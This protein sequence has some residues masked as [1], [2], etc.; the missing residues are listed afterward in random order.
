MAW[1]LEHEIR[2]SGDGEDWITWGLGAL[3]GCGAAWG[4]CSQSG[5]WRCRRRPAPRRRRRPRRRAAPPPTPG[6]CPPSPSRPLPP[7][8]FHQQTLRRVGRLGEVV[9]RAGNERLEEERKRKTGD[10]GERRSLLLDF[11]YASPLSCL[12][13]FRK[14]RDVGIFSPPVFMIF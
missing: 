1:R 3:E 13:A 4:S 7:P 8:L 5:A 2:T 10:N 6:T 12:V 11:G 14:R 9:T